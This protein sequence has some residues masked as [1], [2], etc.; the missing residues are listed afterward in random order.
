MY[1]A[2]ESKRVL[3]TGASEGIGAELAL[4]LAAKGNKLVLAARRREA[5]EDVAQRCRA[6]GAQ[7]WVVPCDVSVQAQCTSLIDTAVASMGG[8][9]VL[10][11]NAGVSMHGWF[12]DITDLD[13]FERLFRINTMSAVWLTHRALSALRQSKGLVVGVSSLAGK[14]GVPARTT[15]CTSKFAMSGFF[16]ALRIELMGSG[17]DVTM[18]FPGVVATEIRRNGLNA[19]GER[20]G[21]SGLAEKGAMSLAQCTSEMIHAM[22]H[23]KREHIMTAQGRLGMLLKSLFPGVIDH[24]ARKALDSDHGGPKKLRR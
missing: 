22:E 1:Q 16:E 9:D 19:N 13:T 15:Y 21:V 14:T 4:A 12:E 2:I 20:A 18:I 5:L 3:I 23:R 11:N 17:V 7:V 8:L 10:V 24:M 6:V